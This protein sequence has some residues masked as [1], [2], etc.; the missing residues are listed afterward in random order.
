MALFDETSRALPIGWLTASLRHLCFTVLR[1]T[2][3][4][5]QESLKRIWKKVVV[6]SVLQPAVNLESFAI[7][8]NGL[9]SEDEQAFDVSRA[10]F[11]TFARLAAL[12]HV[13]RLRG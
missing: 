2:T 1:M 10:Q 7:I 3:V 6:R 11:A 8:R 9:R 12:T 13:R 4:D 5:K